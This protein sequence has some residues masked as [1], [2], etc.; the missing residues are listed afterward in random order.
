MSSRC[1]APVGIRHR[2]V[3]NRPSVRPA[4]D[5]ARPTSQVSS[6]LKWPA[7]LKADQCHTALRSVGG[8]GGVGDGH[9]GSN[10]RWDY[11]RGSWFPAA[12]LK[13]WPP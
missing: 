3:S 4:E 1:A 13:P 11:A 12:R 8:G 6:S 9:A 2:V 5:D 7:V 10:D